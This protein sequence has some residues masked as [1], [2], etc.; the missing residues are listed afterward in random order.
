MIK[1]L[2]LKYFTKYYYLPPKQKAFCD[3]VGIVALLFLVF[4]VV[5]IVAHFGLW[6]QFWTLLVLYYCISLFRFLYKSRVRWYEL[7]EQDRKKG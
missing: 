5:G 2:F 7:Q 4:G 6:I 3:M 1:E